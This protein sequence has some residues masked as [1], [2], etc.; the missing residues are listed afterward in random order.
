MIP[1]KKSS[2]LIKF[3]LPSLIVFSLLVTGLLTDR[4]SAE[5]TEPD[6]SD[7]GSYVLSS[8][9]VNYYIDQRNGSDSW[10]GQSPVFTSGTTGPWR[11]L[12]NIDDTNSF[13]PGD[14]IHLRSGNVWDLSDCQD[15]YLLFRSHGT[16]AN[17]IT[18][19]SYGNG[20]R[21]VI[22]GKYSTLG[23][24]GG[25]TVE[26][27][28]DYV[29]F[30]NI[31]IK[32][33]YSFGM[34]IQRVRAEHHGVIIRNSYIHHNGRDGIYAP[35]GTYN[36]TITNNTIAHTGLRVGGGGIAIMGD[37][38]YHGNDI[39][40]SYN[41]VDTP[42]GDSITL[43][44][45]SSTA[46]THLGTNI[47][48]HHNVINGSLNG[49]GIDLTT[50]SDVYVYNNIVW[51]CHSQLIHM[52][53]S[54]K[55]GKIFNN[56]LWGDAGTGQAYIAVSDIEFY[57]NIM[58]IDGGTAP[59][60]LNICSVNFHSLA[61]EEID[62][63]RNTFVYDSTMTHRGLVEIA[64][65]NRIMGR[66]NFDSNLFTSD[67]NSAPQFFL[68]FQFSAFSA[69]DSNFSCNNNIYGP[70]T[71]NVR[72]L[73]TDVNFNTWQNSYGHDT[74]GQ[75]GD[76]K[77][78]WNNDNTYTLD[79]DSI[80][81]ENSSSN[82]ADT[83]DALGTSVYGIPDVGAM[84]FKPPQVM[85]VDSVEI[86][87]ELDLY[88]DGR[89]CY[90]DPG[91]SSGNASISI[92]PSTPFAGTDGVDKISSIKV[93]Q[94]DRSKEKVL[95]WTEHGTASSRDNDYRIEDLNID[96]RFTIEM[97]G[98]V[99][100]VTRSDDNGT[101]E[102][103]ISRDEDNATFSILREDKPV[104]VSDLLPDH[105]GTGEELDL[106]FIASD[107]DGVKSISMDYWMDNTSFNG[108]LDLS[109]RNGTSNL[110]T[111]N[112]SLDIP[113]DISGEM[114][115]ILYLE[116]MVG[117]TSR[118]REL[119][120]PICDIICPSLAEDATEL[121]KTG[122]GEISFRFNIS[123]NIGFNR[124]LIFLN[125]SGNEESHSLEEVEEGIFRF[126]YING[127]PGLDRIEYH[128]LLEDLSGNIL[129][130]EKKNITIIDILEPSL[131]EDLSDTEAFT[132]SSFY[133][134]ITAFDDR[135]I[136]QVWI[137]YS[138]GGDLGRINGSGTSVESPL[139]IPE[140]AFGVLEYRFNAV[141]ISGNHLG[142]PAVS[143]VIEDNIPPVLAGEVFRF[144]VTTGDL[145]TLSFAVEEN[146]ALKEALFHMRGQEA[147]VIEEVMEIG[148]DNISI[149]LEVPADITG[150][151]FFDLTVV[152]TSD[153]SL[154][155]RDHRINVRDNDPP[156][157]DPTVTRGTE[158]EE[159]NYT[160][161]TGVY[162]NIGV[163]EVHLVI[164]DEMEVQMELKD[165]I[166]ELTMNYQ[167]LGL[168]AGNYTYYFRASDLFGNQDRSDEFN[169]YIPK[170]VPEE[171][172]EDPVEPSQPDEGPSETVDNTSTGGDDIP[173]E[174]E[175]EE[176]PVTG[177]PD[178]LNDIQDIEDTDD[179]NME[180][181][182]II[183]L[184]LLVAIVTLF[185]FFLGRRSLSIE[186][187]K[188]GIDETEDQLP[189]YQEEPVVEEEL[190]E[191]ELI[192]EAS[193]VSEIED[194]HGQEE[195]EFIEEEMEQDISE[196][197]GIESDPDLEDLIK[198]ID[199]L[200]GF[201][202]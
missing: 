108:T 190:S 121:L 180:L 192:E 17:P 22:D 101:I 45:G 66:V 126:D 175:E 181:I 124:T 61:V 182:I 43:H 111:W 136:D 67:T 183:A 141:D 40:V 176:E 146:I 154:I 129:I 132:G 56:I 68:H 148:E 58:R 119:S 134:N 83:I 5:E 145:H 159:R 191:E 73:N 64:D 88:E 87:R 7:G 36:L 164:V 77:I 41:R 193:P 59:Y 11:S 128:L 114:N 149:S 99:Q 28:G 21:P 184:G 92:I 84:E 48:I 127:D 186:D 18:I 115:F 14:T 166:Y 34:V 80:C 196:P 25:D 39:E 85:G 37:G 20:S 96:E 161:F 133:F 173:S 90:T 76:P 6:N 13:N 170:E 100:L 155:S 167:E 49:D 201:L 69:T 55:K 152:D 81:L 130:T 1:I 169:L 51:D 53:S 33:T 122:T 189:D 89:F 24:S 188:E 139:W 104:I 91:T 86:G 60:A 19:T 137:T 150:E 199:S 177:I 187:L 106:L 16:R 120:I 9:P 47:S 54:F 117:T 107:L 12:D 151:Y 142:T 202:R 72:N 78:T 62:V 171:V 165:G 157:F 71:F 70:G 8:N 168:A 194:P 147:T 4:T 138:I 200:E 42:Q 125:I 38:T 98:G 93:K 95:E 172:P 2:V 160:F 179:T 197:D 44:E 35:F 94:F 75:T 118:T 112:S 162:D 65:E 3:I 97:D 105:I 10:N 143:I 116:D 109:L 103:E 50:G 74:S 29:T 46:E 63:Y 110:G 123:E 15:R 140:D 158:I 178:D 57:N 26:I 153:N 163:E 30:E 185:A 174:G 131:V 79:E 27:G 31:E 195:M 32:D 82:I 52:D 198:E 135:G 102:F 144:N 23:S 156:V 113:E